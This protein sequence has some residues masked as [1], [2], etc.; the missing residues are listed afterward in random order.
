MVY[1]QNPRRSMPFMVFSITLA[2][3]LVSGCQT[4]L[5][6]TP[7]L[8]LSDSACKNTFS[9]VPPDFQKNTVDILY[10][11]DRKPSVSKQGKIEYGYGRSPSIAYGSCVVEM[12]KNASWETLVEN[13]CKHRR[14]VSL[15]LSIKQ[16]TEIARSVD[17][18]I[19]L[20]KN[21]DGSIVEDPQAKAVQEEMV[22][23]FHE[24]I[25]RRLDMTPRK[26][27]FIFIHGYSNTFEDPMYVMAGLWH[28]IGR[29]GVPIVY[30]WP[31]G[32][33][34]PMQ[35]YTY[36][37]E[38]CEFTSYHLK[39]FLTVLAECPDLQKIHIISHSRGTD[40]ATTAIGELFNE[41]R[42]AHKSPR[43]ELKIGNLIV[44]APDVDMEVAI[45][46]FAT[47]RL[48]LDMD[49]IT[50][51]VSN[52][53]RAMEIS[54]WLFS[55]GRRLGQLRVEDIPDYIKKSMKYMDRVQIINAKVSTD[56]IGHSYFHASPAVSSDV[57]LVLRDSCAPGAQNG[58][59]LISL[60][61]NYWRIT[62]DYL[63]HGAPSCEPK[64]ERK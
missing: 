2:L 54:D 29:Q 42:A 28:F 46:R 4:Q 44:A 62:D 27:A 10:V 17:I 32:G 53:D 40:V 1:E 60:D 5:M 13:S 12:G 43:E 24:E 63:I 8:Y 35:G 47:K 22:R 19:P 52:S 25:K 11:T 33:K 36:D 16:T 49:R 38:S 50:M 30:T 51:Y 9:K 59:P 56:F 7:N 20:A 6:P 48:A 14:S 64:Q 58:R 61:Q 31:S 41:I 39:V 15:P 34:S 3:L 45:Q 57:I 26:E 18:P 55:S 23:R 21:P 37:R